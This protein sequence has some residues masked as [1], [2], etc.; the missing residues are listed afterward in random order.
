MHYIL[1]NDFNLVIADYYLR[2]YAAFDAHKNKD[3]LFD[4][5]DRIT[6]NRK[7]SFSTKNLTALSLAFFYT[8][9]E[10]WAFEKFHADQCFDYQ[11]FHLAFWL[12]IAAHLYKKGRNTGFITQVITYGMEYFL[13]IP[14]KLDYDNAVSFFSNIIGGSLKDPNLIPSL[15]LA[16]VDEQMK[17][18]APKIGDTQPQFLNGN[19]NLGVT[20]SIINQFSLNIIPN[21]IPYTKSSTTSSEKGSS[22][23]IK[24]EDKDKDK[25]KERK[26][27]PLEQELEK[28]QIET[29]NTNIIDNNAKDTSQD[30]SSASSVISNIFAFIVSALKIAVGLCLVFLLILF[31][32]ILIQCTSSNAKKEIEKPQE[33][34][35]SQQA[36]TQLPLQCMTAERKFDVMSEIGYDDSLQKLKTE[37]DIVCKAET[38]KA[39]VDKSDAPEN[40]LDEA[41]DAQ[42]APDP[43]DIPEDNK[44]IQSPMVYEAQVALSRLGFSIAA[45]GINGPQT[46]QAVKA[47]Q[48]KI[49]VHETGKI[50]QQLLSDLTSE[51]ML[52]GLQ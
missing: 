1:T 24:T 23:K 21:L 14:Y 26:A 12:T 31:L 13:A 45:D 15:I 3:E 32:L 28:E 33:T 44:T 48:N 19:C 50:D 11:K 2:E 49:G 27:E 7:S 10:R 38:Q 9:H 47:F 17:C 4:L 51:L 40:M 8:I 20:E 25:Y 16:L 30:K 37:R 46:Q 39:P 35:T 43:K 22:Y 36:A 18:A 42:T 29:P 6:R 52:Q 5:I 41:G 34:V